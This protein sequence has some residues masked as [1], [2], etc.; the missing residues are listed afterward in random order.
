MA[1]TSSM[2]VIFSR[3]TATAPWRGWSSS[4]SPF[5]KPPRA[6]A[7]GGMETAF[8]VYWVW[9]FIVSSLYYWNSVSWAVSF[10]S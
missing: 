10:M 8:P 9:N 4:R 3:S 7:G 5:S 1:L 6:I 2:A